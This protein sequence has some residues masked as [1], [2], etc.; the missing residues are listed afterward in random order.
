[1]LSVI[2]IYAPEDQSAINS[3]SKIKA[4]FE[5]E[6]CKANVKTAAS[7]IIPDITAADIILLGSMSKG[8]IPVH[9]DFKEITLALQGINLA[10]KTA[11]IFTVDSINTI[12]AFREILHD[13][14]I[15]ICDE[16][17]FINKENNNSFTEADWVKK[18]IPLHKERSVHE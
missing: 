9:P 10:G 14:H 12:N 5:T 4:A 3:T 16:G 1:M 15:T 6:G 18:I 17:F 7:A 13:S 2:I 11:G 8:K